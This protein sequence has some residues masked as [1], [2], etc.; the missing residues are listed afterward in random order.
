MTRAL[1][2]TIAVSVLS[3][4]LTISLTACGNSLKTTAPNAPTGVIVE[5]GSGQVA[6]SWVAPSGRVSSYTV[7]YS[8]TDPVTTSSPARV[9]D[10][11]H[12][13]TT[14]TGLTG[15]TTYY[16]IVT[17]VNSYGESPA[18]DQISATP[19]VKYTNATLSGPWLIMVTG[20]P[21]NNV[22]ITFDGNGNVNEFGALT[23]NT[24]NPGT[25][26]V[27]T[28]GTFSITLNS[29][30]SPQELVAGSLSSIETGSFNLGNLAGTIN[31]IS[32]ISA[33]Q[34]TWAGTLKNVIGNQNTYAITMATDLNGII[35]TVTSSP[36]GVFNSP[37][38]SLSNKM[39]CENS[40]LVAHVTLNQTD[41]YSQI[42]FSGIVTGTTASGT[43]N[44]VASDPTIT[45]RG[46]FSFTRQLW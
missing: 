14:I 5:S 24:V 43:F 21:N 31:K 26:A 39:Y 27:A 45:Q 19:A 29:L 46:T 35:T 8:T 20:L 37:V 42:Q 34:G 13:S 28:D 40:V 25:Y 18:S 22:Y 15:D 23:T 16:F 30:F 33:C 32:D 6:I 3:V 9:T 44:S 2:R 41:V 38:S 1:L 10:I 36:L 12:T 11:S 4:L 7:Y 17:A